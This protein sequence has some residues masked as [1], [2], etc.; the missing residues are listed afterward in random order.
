MEPRVFRPGGSEERRVVDETGW[1]GDGSFTPALIEAL[2]AMAAVESLTIEDAPSS[3][4]D[5]GY[6]FIA[7]EIYVAFKTE[8]RHESVKHLG[9]I[10]GSREAVVPVMALRGLADALAGTDGIG[11]PDYVD[12]AMLQYLRTERIVAPYQTRGIKVVEMVRI[13]EA[14]TRR[15]E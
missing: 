11:A 5:A 13:Y 4:V 12:E 2:T 7:N 9:I 15:R 8:I 6:V 3:R 14:G 1:T 10:P